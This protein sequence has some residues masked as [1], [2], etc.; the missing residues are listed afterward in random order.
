MPIEEAKSDIETYLKTQLPEL[1]SSPEFAELGQRRAGGLFH[2]AATTVKYLTLLD[3]ITVGEQTEL[4]DLLSKSYE[5]VSSSD[6]TS[7]VDDLYRQS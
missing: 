4:N 2:Y 5:P 3:S 7:L 1:V 6:A